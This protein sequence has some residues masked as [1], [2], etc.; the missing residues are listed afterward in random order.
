MALLGNRFVVRRFGG[1]SAALLSTLYHTCQDPGRAV[2]RLAPSWRGYLLPAVSLSGPSVR[3]LLSLARQ[4]MGLG[5]SLYPLFGAVLGDTVVG[6]VLLVGRSVRGKYMTSVRPGS[7]D[8]VRQRKRI[9][10]VESRVTTNK[11][12]PAPVPH[13]RRGGE[14]ILRCSASRS[15]RLRECK[16][17]AQRGL[18][19]CSY[20]WVRPPGQWL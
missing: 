16:Q 19:L 2:H 11:L 7:D 5:K 18:F 17:R 6:F 10:Q 14:E 4:T 9:H 12:A 15:G 8:P 3:S 1:S 13:G 20:P